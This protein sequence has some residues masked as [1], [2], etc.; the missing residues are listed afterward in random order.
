MLSRDDRAVGL[1]VGLA[2]GD[3]LGA[4][5]E[6]Q[7]PAAIADR[8]DW[9][10]SYPGGGPFPWA[11]GEFTDDTQM[12][13]VLA[14]HLS[15]TRG[16]IDQAELASEFAGW[17]T[18][19]STLDVGIQTIGV[20]SR[21]AS[22]TPWREATATVAADREGNGSL[23]RVAPVALAAPTRDQAAKLAELQ[24]AVTHPNVLSI[25]GCRAYAAILWVE[26][27]GRPVD[28]LESTLLAREPGVAG[29]I[30]RA[31]DPTPPAMSGFVVDT[32]ASALWAVH[33]ATNFED[34]V[35]RAVSLGQDADTV[36][37]VAGALAGARW[38]ADSISG[39]PK[40][41]LTSRHPMF[42]DEYPGVLQSL[43]AE[44]AS[45]GAGE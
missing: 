11:P 16:S 22:G 36:G 19:S 13:L 37:A 15:A 32:L 10:F 2:V 34:A 33:H 43:A 25:D 45:I 30:A 21:V 12:A 6:F 3:A 18:H 8:R 29:A 7:P 5:V 39:R 41:D 31:L 42:R 14:R 35:W 44:L 28:L 17:A 9:L 26:L 20:L 38:G 23:M 27:A 24:S 40:A 1:L 4:P